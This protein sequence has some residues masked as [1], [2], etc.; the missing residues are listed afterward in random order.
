MRYF[1][2][3]A[4]M[5]AL[6]FQAQA[7][8]IVDIKTKP[9]AESRSVEAITCTTCQAADPQI[10]MLYK[11]PVLQGAAQKLEIREI[12]GE[13]KLVRTEAMMGGSPVELVSTPTPDIM[14][15]LGN[16]PIDGRALAE[17]G[18]DGVDEMMTTAVGAPKIAPGEPVAASI[19]DLSGPA[20]QP[21]KEINPDDFQLRMK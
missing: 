19:A 2:L 15:A 1:V 3:T 8:S 16:A 10:N 6:A 4:A 21:V 5:T 18:K 13:K 17:A 11:V 14:A 9:L 12:N 20:E 7:S